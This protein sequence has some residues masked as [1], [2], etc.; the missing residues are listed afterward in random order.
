MLL[1]AAAHCHSYGKSGEGRPP[2]VGQRPRCAGALERL[3]SQ[4]QDAFV[5]AGETVAQLL[6]S[7]EVNWWAQVH[8]EQRQQLMTNLQQ[9]TF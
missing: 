9:V 1:E 7:I 6:E 4:L 2:A 3:A 8:L 5:K